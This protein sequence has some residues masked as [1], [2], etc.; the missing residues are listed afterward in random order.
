MGNDYLQPVYEYLTRTLLRLTQLDLSSTAAVDIGGGDGQWLGFLLEKGLKFG[1]VVDIDSKRIAEADALLRANFPADRWQTIHADVMS[2]P[3]ME[4][5]FELVVSRSSLH[6]WSDA[7]LAW[8]EIARITKP[9]GFVFVGRGYGP[10]LPDDL[11]EIV[12]K[13]KRLSHGD[14]GDSFQEPPSMPVEELED[15]IRNAGF[16]IVERIPDHKAHWLL[17]VRNS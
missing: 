4:K 3:V 15:V 6:L 12:K 16:A 1:S 8:Q 10:D 14:G 2:I 17:A 11:R 7:M 13:E 5:S 9:G